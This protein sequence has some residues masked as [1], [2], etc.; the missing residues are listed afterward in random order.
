MMPSMDSPIGPDG[1]PAILDGGA[2]R[3]H[4]GRYWWN[5]VAWV[6][7]NKSV[8]GQWMV[9]IG[10]TLLL[11]ALLGYAVYTTI[12]TQSEYTV[13]YY[14]GVMAFFA[15]LLAIYRF[16]GRWSWFGTVVRA[17]CL[18]LALLKVLTLVAHPLP[19]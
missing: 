11:V 15:T 14:A 10:I 12:A 13:G 2:W 5:G 4:N 3:S 9:K 1:L 7:A 6:P 19:T 17:G 16:S 18:F 8:T